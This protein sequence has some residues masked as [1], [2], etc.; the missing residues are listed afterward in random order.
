MAMRHKATQHTDE[1]DPSARLAEA[2]NAFLLGVYRCA[3]E[4]YQPRI[5][6][7]TGVQL[8]KID[9]WDYSQLHRHIACDIEEPRMSLLLFGFLKSLVLEWRVRKRSRQLIGAY[10]DHARKYAACYYADAIYVSFAASTP[11]DEVA[12]VVAVHELSHALWERLEGEP[13]HAKRLPPA[14]QEKY[15]LLVEGYAVYAASTWFWISIRP[16]SGTICR[17]PSTTAR[18]FI[19]EGSREFGNLSSCSAR[20]FFSEFRANGGTIELPDLRMIRAGM[21]SVVAVSVNRK[22]SGV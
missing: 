8:G 17:T 19:I 2:A 11:H 1:S 9:V 20:T 15:Q 12:P 7:R 10:E 13:F 4:S 6:R 22:P 18:A 16:V 14:D 5:E 21:P 3:V